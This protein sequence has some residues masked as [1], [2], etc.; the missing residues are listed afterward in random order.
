MVA[1]DRRGH[2]RSDQTDT[3]NDMTTYAADVAELA[4][5]LDLKNAIHIGHSTSG[6]EVARYVAH[7]EKFSWYFFVA[8]IFDRPV[9]KSLF[10]RYRIAL[11]RALAVF[12]T[13]FAAQS[14]YS[15]L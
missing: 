7:A 14:I 11:E 9:I 12:L 6:G 1:H 5:A 13:L 4:S 2:G 3:G 8:L 15:I 10:L